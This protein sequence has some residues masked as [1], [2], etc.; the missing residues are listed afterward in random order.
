VNS[1]NYVIIM[2]CSFSYEFIQFYQIFFIRIMLDLSHF[3][4]EI[5]PFQQL[6][7]NH[8]DY[9]F[10]KNQEPL[11]INNQDYLIEWMIFVFLGGVFMHFIYFI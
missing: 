11:L 7:I 1:L 10:I 6:M 8:V 4:L 2:V 9:N 5:Q 3:I